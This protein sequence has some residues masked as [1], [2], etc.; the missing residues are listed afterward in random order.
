MPESWE[1]WNIT[2]THQKHINNLPLARQFALTAVN[3][4]SSAAEQVMSGTLLEHV[5]FV[6]CPRLD[7][8]DGNV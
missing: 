8:T 5:F 6:S 4:K 7:V 3:F 2:E 1:K